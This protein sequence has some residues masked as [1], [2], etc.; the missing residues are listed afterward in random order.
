MMP[1]HS[2]FPELAARETRSVHVLHDGGVLPPGEY[3]FLEY[4][5]EEPGCDCRRGLLRVTTSTAPDTVLA[6]INFGWESP[7]FYTR[8]MHGHAEAGREVTA[9][10]LD[11]LN[12][13][14]RHADHL[15]A[16]FRDILKHDAD[17]V[18]R[19]ARH[20][21]M[22]KNA[23]GH[24]PTPGHIPEVLERTLPPPTTIPEILRQLQDLPERCDFAPYEAA[25]RAA[26][27]QRD[28]LVPELIAAIDRVSA[29]PGPH[30]Q[31]DSTDYLHVF[32]IYL[33]AQFRETRALDCFLRFFSL[34]G[35]QSL[36]LTGDMVTE[37]GAAV[38]ASVCGGDPAPL[39]R[40]IHDEAVNEFVR[41]Q[42]IQALA[43][44]SL[45]NE[46]PRDAAVAELRRLFRTLPKPGSGSVW[47]ALISTICAFHAPELADEARQAFAEGWV[48]ED[49][50]R[51]D[52]LETDLAQP[53]DGSPDG[54]RARNQPIDAV[55]ECSCWLCFRDGDE[56]DGP[57]D[58]EDRD[59][60]AD[61]CEADGTPC[62]A[63]AAN[64][65]PPFGTYREPE[66]PQPYIAPPEV[67]RNE[68]CPCGSGRK[69]K[70][71][72]GQN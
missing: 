67:G 15:L 34:P 57:G 27:E 2:R 22:F 58:D 29:N 23:P 3:G 32:A 70:K 60:D 65:A 13:Q 55:A 28:A 35:E 41:G 45:W 38:L 26:L 11:P 40:L 30:L 4:Y 33:L 50:I 18:A 39:L 71:C 10:S 72:C 59:D 7:E 12:L 48:D 44:Q 43:V 25:L 69:Y 46:R 31:Q 61:S 9:A 54:F 14:S 66:A 64:D 52:H 36:D 16:I 24:P 19:L 53:P 20:Y 63:G 21:E 47:A 6:T 5:C 68:P 42:A 8:W 62:Y 56:D 49:V 51:L 17:Y 1:F 37:H